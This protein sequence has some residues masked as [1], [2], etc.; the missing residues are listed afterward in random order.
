MIKL[1]KNEFL[2]LSFIKLLFVLIV[3]FTSIFLI[4][5]VNK[6]SINVFETS[7][8]LIPFLGLFIVIL[9]GGIISN[10]FTNGTIRMYLT[11]PVKRYKI[12]LS[13]L[14][15]IFIVI[16]LLLVFIIFVYFI[17]LKIYEIE[18]INIGQV[19][20]LFIYSIPLFFTAI[21]VLSISTLT[22]STSASVGISLFLLLFSGII[23]QIFFGI[24]MNFIEYTFLPYMDFT[25]FENINDIKIM[26]AELGIHLSINRG[27]VILL[28]YS[29]VFYIISNYIFVKADIKN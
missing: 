29:F 16:I 22:K 7:I 21:V 19:K 14:L 27:A 1:I 12:Y 9:F 5:Y 6:S 3:L 10:E 4:V 18:D 25:I 17:L 20:K 28:I 23:S 26:N 2:K 15:T 13:K 24:N 11:K 8:Y